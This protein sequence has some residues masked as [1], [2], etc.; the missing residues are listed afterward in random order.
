MKV[1]LLD[2]FDSFTYN[3]AHY[4]ES[5][6][7]VVDVID[8]EQV[9]LNMLNDYDALVL[10]PGPGLPIQAGKLMDVI[11]L[12]IASNL[13]ILGICLGMQAI[14]LHFSDHLFNQQL[15]K[16]GVA[17]LITQ[18]SAKSAL[19]QGLPEQFKVGLYHSWAVEVQIDSPL[20]VTSLSET[21]IVM[22]IEHQSAPIYGVQFH[23]ESIMTPDGRTIIENFLKLV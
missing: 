19:F 4:L 21:N 7:A 11:N 20:I 14:A 23:P 15:V 10:S 16:H 1:L 8:N 18:T 5:C 6:D 9:D 22:S 3:I 12:G 13:P 2:N 17:E